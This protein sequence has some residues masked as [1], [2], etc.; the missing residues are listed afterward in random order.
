MAMAPLP[1][2]AL[3][4]WDWYPPP[5]M[6]PVAGGNVLGVYTS[7]VVVVVA[8]HALA[9]SDVPP[10]VLPHAPVEE[11]GFDG[12][13]SRWFAEEPTANGLSENG[14]AMVER[15]G[16]VYVIFCA[17]FVA[18]V[19]VSSSQD[20]VDV[21]TCS[22]LTAREIFTPKKRVVRSSM[23]GVFRPISYDTRRNTWVSRVGTTGVNFYSSF[24]FALFEEGPTDDMPSGGPF[25]LAWHAPYATRWDLGPVLDRIPDRR[26]TGIDR[27]R[28]VRWGG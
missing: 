27:I 15:V 23:P 26:D 22:V 6:Y 13:S 19:A 21:V 14:S 1:P 16:D 28:R 7:L 18:L 17:P 3:K 8:P 5:L 11:Y 9:F 10:G 4:D 2:F 25:R 20:G 24:F 12:S